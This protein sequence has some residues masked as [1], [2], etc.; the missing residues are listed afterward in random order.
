MWG[1]PIAYGLGPG[2]LYDE[3]MSQGF[4]VT[5]DE[6]RGLYDK[7][8]STYRTAVDFLRESGKKATAQGFLANL[9]GRRRNWRVPDPD[10]FTNKRYD[11]EYIGKMSKI[12]R[13][14]GNHLIQ[15]VNVDITKDAMVQIRRY[16]KKHKV[17]TRFVNAI[18][19]EIVTRTH[20]DDSAS[21][22]EAKLKIM[23]ESAEKWVRNVPMVVDG[24][25]NP[26][27]TK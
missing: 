12:E 10:Q 8:C 26:Y 24:S 11:P 22:H 16:R 25:V 13:E 1:K 5:R 3:L 7:Y 14:G 4:T 6:S 19:D 17:R 9:N 18:Y 27:W 15:S 21:F 2:R 20:K 23:R